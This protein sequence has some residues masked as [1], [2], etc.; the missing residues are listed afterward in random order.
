MSLRTAGLSGCFFPDTPSLP[1][2][3]LSP[4]FPS[5]FLGSLSTFGSLREATIKERER[6]S[7]CLVPPAWAKIRFVPPEGGLSPQGDLSQGLVGVACP[8]HAAQPELAQELA[9]QLLPWAG[10]RHGEVAARAPGD[11]GQREVGVQPP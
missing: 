2:S 5:F 1:P 3:P 4:F 10:P 7:V 6:A 8:P 11:L 9:P